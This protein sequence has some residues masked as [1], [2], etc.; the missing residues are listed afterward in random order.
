MFQPARMPGDKVREAGCLGG[1]L[2]LPL[3][4][5]SLEGNHNEVSPRCL[6]WLFHSALQCPWMVGRGEKLLGYQG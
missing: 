6:L 4:A 5:A 2:G 1:F 3:E